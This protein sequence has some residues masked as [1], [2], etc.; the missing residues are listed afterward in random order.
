M[1][2]NQ[3]DFTA[4]APKRV[5]YTMATLST[6]TAEVKGSEGNWSDMTHG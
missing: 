2:I 5:H 4:T 1:I 3:T 6:R